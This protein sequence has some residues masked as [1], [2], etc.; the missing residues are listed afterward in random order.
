MSRAIDDEVKQRLKE[1]SDSQ[2]ATVTTTFS[3]ICDESG[4]GG[5]ILHIDG[6]CIYNMACNEAYERTKKHDSIMK[7]LSEATLEDLA[8]AI[9]LKTK[10]ER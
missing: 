8:E 7:A 4:C 2:L 10:E 9:K 5:C 3:D 1:M 6:S